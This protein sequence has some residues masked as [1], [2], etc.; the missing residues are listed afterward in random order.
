[1]SLSQSSTEKVR[2]GLIALLSPIWDKWSDLSIASKEAPHLEKIQ[3][4]ELENRMLKNELAYLSKAHFLRSEEIKSIPARVIFRPPELWGSTL[5]VDKGEADNDPTAPPIVAKNSPVVLGSS[6]VGVIDYV[7][8]HQSR[9]RLIT[10]AH[11]NPS[12]RALRGG[13]QDAFIEENID[14]LVKA[15]QE[16]QERWGSL[17]ERTALQ[18]LLQQFQSHIR[19]K[20]EPLY[21]AKGQLFGSSSALWRCRTHTLRGTGFNYDFPDDKG[22]AR[23]LR[24]GKILGKANAPAIPLLKVNDLLVTSGMDGLFPPGLRVAVVTHIDLLKEGDYCYELEAQPTAS[25]LNELSLLFIIPPLQ[26]D[27]FDR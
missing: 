16:R 7:G 10:D 9:V 13:D 2:G 11:L 5:W 6:L 1:M 12:V 14:L 22:E 3:A 26:Q 20:R 24:S 23:D 8:R 27:P 18:Q 21:L 19:V 17:E 25:N 4:L 15:L